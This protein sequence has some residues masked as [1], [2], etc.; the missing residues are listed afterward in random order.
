MASPTSRRSIGRSPQRPVRGT[1]CRPARPRSHDHQVRTGD[2][3]QQ[4]LRTS[5]ARSP[6]ARRPSGA[7]G[8]PVGRRPVAWHA[9]PA[10]PAP[11]KAT[12]ALSPVSTVSIATILHPPLAALMLGVAQPLQLTTHQVAHT[13]ATD[14]RPWRIERHE[15]AL[16]CPA[17]P[18]APLVPARIRSSRLVQQTGQL[19]LFL[20]WTRCRDTPQCTV[21]R[22]RRSTPRISTVLW[23]QALPLAPLSL[24]GSTQGYGHKANRHQTRQ[25]SRRA[26]FTCTSVC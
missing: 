16:L 6:A 10:A 23:Y 11:A 26:V 13:R 15:L 8:A 2:P 17:R 7:P 3:L 22:P 20:S 14:Q 4:R 24:D 19:K 1:S 21:A 18:L 12:V 5:V 9:G 25:A